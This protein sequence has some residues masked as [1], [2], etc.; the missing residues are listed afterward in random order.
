METPRR[1]Y[2]TKISAHKM[3]EKDSPTLTVATNTLLQAIQDEYLRSHEDRRI[4]MLKQF[5][6]YIVDK[7]NTN[8]SQFDG[9]RLVALAQAS[10]W[11]SLSSSEWKKLMP[12][13][14]LVLKT[15]HPLA[16]LCSYLAVERRKAI[17]HWQ[18]STFESLCQRINCD[19]LVFENVEQNLEST[20]TRENFFL[21]GSFTQDRANEIESCLR[22]SITSTFAPLVEYHSLI[23]ALQNNFTIP[24]QPQISEFAQLFRSDP[25]GRKILE[26]L[27][28]L[29]W[30]TAPNKIS[31]IDEFSRVD[32][33]LSMLKKLNIAAHCSIPSN[34]REKILSSTLKCLSYISEKYL[35]MCLNRSSDGT[36]RENCGRRQMFIDL[37]SAFSE[38]S[39]LL[40]DMY[41]EGLL[42]AE[43][44]EIGL[45]NGTKA[46]DY[47]N[48][49][50]FGKMES[51]NDKRDIERQISRRN[52]L[53]STAKWV[54]KLEMA[55]L[56]EDWERMELLS[57]IDK[58]LISCSQCVEIIEVMKVYCSIETCSRIFV[59]SAKILK[60][61]IKFIF[62]LI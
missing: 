39:L 28:V 42:R 23:T 10:S 1:I 57:G 55:I 6:E 2:S 24:S 14:N 5:G 45:N 8:P 17:I 46:Y 58:P 15:L 40:T 7:K 62:F 21:V 47:V 43:S 60:R 25:A 34:L 61:I 44:E 50:I 18:T 11:F 54:L 27:R 51:E 22:S 30:L 12:S 33:S 3:P 31:S 53:V 37:A 49:L 20:S 4:L 41:R 26:S 52:D 32:T 16:H 59:P 13:D 9:K 48:S 35:S 29:A 19:D 36:L 38:L 56:T